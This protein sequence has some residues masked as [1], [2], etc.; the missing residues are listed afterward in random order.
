MD[1]PYP[2]PAVAE[3]E[4]LERVLELGDGHR[5]RWGLWTAFVLALA[6]HA[7]AGTPVLRSF[8]YLTELARTV[9][10]SMQDRLRSQVDI[11]VEKPPPPPPP[12]PVQEKEPE[13]PPPVAH[14]APPPPHEAAPKPTP[15]AQAAP[16][17]TAEPNPDEPLDLTDRGFVTGFGDRFPGGVTS[18]RGTSNT[19]V[20]NVAA[21]P[22]GTGTGTRPAAAPAPTVNLTRAAGPGPGSWSDCGFPPE[23]DAE[24]INF[25][26]VKIM[27]TVKADGRARSVTVLTDPGFG[28][29]AWARQCA[30]RKTYVPALN[31]AG[32]PVEQTTPP[33]TVHFER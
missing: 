11:D 32:E 8:P 26:L 29:A 17:L 2:P 13:P 6:A 4:P 22:T 5:H 19:A 1:A 21:S 31:L 15:A 9:R 28:F 7:S 10:K 20:R 27:V 33:F 30:L 24:G 25:K 18:N 16:L 12:P 3:P 14:A 23:A